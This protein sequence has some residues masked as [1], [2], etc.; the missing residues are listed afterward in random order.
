MLSTFIRAMVSAFQSI[1]SNGRPIVLMASTL[2]EA[3]TM[4]ARRSALVKL[5]H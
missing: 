5:L 3:H 2:D 1:D 4:L